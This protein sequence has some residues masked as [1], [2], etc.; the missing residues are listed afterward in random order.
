MVGQSTLDEWD[1]FCRIIDIA[2]LMNSK[3]SLQCE[4][5]LKIN[6]IWKSLMSLAYFDCPDIERKRKR[7]KLNARVVSSQKSSQ[8]CGG[9]IVSL[10]NR[11]Y[12]VDV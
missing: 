11:E 5:L 6:I 3:T 9:A 4:M 7:V 2:M 1:S 12:M 8:N 10:S